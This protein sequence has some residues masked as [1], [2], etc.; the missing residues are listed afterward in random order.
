MLLL[1]AGGPDTR[2]DIHL[3]TS[4]ANP[5]AQRDR[6]GL[7]DGGGTPLAGRRSS[8]RVAKCSAAR[9]R[10][11]PW[12]TSVAIATILTPGIPLATLVELH[13]GPALFQEVKDQQRGASAFHGIGGPL[14]DG[15]S[16]PQFGLLLCV[17]A[18]AALGYP[19]VPTSTG[20]SRK[21]PVSTSG[22][23]RMASARVRQWSFCTPLRTARN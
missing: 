23:S 16:R 21:A 10:S 14:A 7:L 19:G 3:P 17:E 1:E 22:P 4:L 13:R 12:S 8:G 5:R 2:P 9:V 15:P 20:R 11:T 6:L 18:A